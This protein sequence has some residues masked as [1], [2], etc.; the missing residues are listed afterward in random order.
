MIIEL[1]DNAN[2]TGMNRFGV[3]DKEFARG[4]IQER[5]VSKTKL[6]DADQSMIRA[7]QATRQIVSEE[8]KYVLTDPQCLTSNFKVFTNNKGANENSA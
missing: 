8:V 3:A 5:E 2:A 4:L 7:R 1:E 6:I